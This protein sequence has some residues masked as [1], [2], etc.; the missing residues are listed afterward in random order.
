MKRFLLVSLCLACSFIVYAG[1]VSEKQALAKACQFMPGKT[2]LVNNLSYGSVSAKNGSNAP[3]YVF[4]AENDSGFVIVSGDDRTK[5]ILGYSEKGALNEN[6]LPENVEAWLKY[7]AEAISSLEDSPLV[8]EPNIATAS[9]SNVTPLIKTEW[10]QESPWNDQCTF[11]GVSCLTG[12]VATA[13]AQVMNFHK[14][15][16]KVKAIDGYTCSYT[17]PALPAATFSWKNMCNTY[18]YYDE[19]TSTQKKAVATLMRYCGQ[20]ARIGYGP[21]SSGGSYYSA[22]IALVNYFGYSRGVR[23]IQSRDYSPEDW[24]NEIYKELAAGYPILYAG[25]STTNHNHAFIVDGYKDG[26]YHVNWGWGGRYDGYF[27]LTVMDSMGPDAI[28]WTY[29]EGQGAIIGIKPNT[30]DTLED[31]P[32]LTIDHLESVS[33]NEVTRSSSNDNFPI[34]I[35]YGISASPFVDIGDDRACDWCINRVSDWCIAVYKGNTMIGSLKQG[36]V[37][38]LWCGESGILWEHPFGSGLAD[39]TY[40]IQA[41]YQDKDGKIHKAEKS[42][43]RYIKAVIKGNKLTMTNYPLIGAVKLSKSKVTI[44]KGKTLTLTATV[45][46]S[47]LEDKSV[48]WSSSDTKIATVSAEGKVKGVKVGTATITCTS[49]TG[50][51]ATCKV[52]VGA[53]TL[54]QTKAIVK[55][56]KTVT[57]T[58]TVY[59]STLT[60]KSVTWK[61]SD[62]TIATVT[63]AGKVKGVKYGTATITCTSNATGLKATCKVTVGNVSLDR[64]E[65]FIRKGKSLTLTAKVYPITLTDKSV[66]WESSNTKIATVSSDGKVTGVKVG[67][68]TITCT[69][70][71]TGL[72]KTCKVTIGAVTLDQKVVSI[73]KGKTVTLTPTVYPSSL[74]DKSVTWKSSDET[75]ATVSTAG[76]VKG[77]KYGTATITCTSNVT[78]LSTTCKVTVGNVKLDQTEAAI[79]KGKTVTLKATVYPSSL[80]DKTV[81]W[82]SSDTKIATVSS[83]GKVK[84]VRAGTATITCTSNATGLTA[85]CKVTVTVSSGTRSIEGDDDEATGIDEVNIESTEAQ[86]YDVYDLSGRKVAHQV[87]TLEGLPNG[88]YIVN[89]KKMLKK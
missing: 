30:G 32:L 69:S 74:E 66:K 24:E 28:D 11:D 53:V 37:S 88:I 23:S 73:K 48:T 77:I 83:S 56:G 36:E 18:S 9:R 57:L 76:K 79:V 61:S 43:E 14:H 16:S 4:S 21:N 52:T 5:A 54:D 87:T 20:A 58:P 71:A 6:K 64:S 7:Y 17:V 44:Q 82:E 46:P 29:S 25:G 34:N 59:P 31:Y 42:D 67:T 19:R 51:S 12:C 40:K 1:P 60:D 35:E 41:V 10:S 26:L 86:P 85:T 75:I 49:S 72:S 55:K 8:G 27:V 81:T 39:G 70:V 15:P 65:A 13:M 2:F 33:G 80:T 38:R 68:A 89:G 22:I 63:T 47:S 45:S 50:L 78:G 3:Y 84:G 62:E